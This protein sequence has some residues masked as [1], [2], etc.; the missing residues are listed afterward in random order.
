MSVSSMFILP[1]VIQDY[2]TGL[3]FLNKVI[4]ENLTGRN[5]EAM[6]ILLLFFKCQRRWKGILMQD[7]I[8]YFDESCMQI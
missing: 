4:R 6:E 3:L 7:N 5:Y 8:F 1:C 2:D